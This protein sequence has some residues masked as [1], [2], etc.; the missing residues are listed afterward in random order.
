LL[1]ESH[2]PEGAP[3]RTWLE[4]SGAQLS[5]LEESGDEA[6]HAMALPPG[7]VSA[8]LGRYARPL[9][10]SLIDLPEAGGLSLPQG[11]RL[12]RLRFRPRYDVIAKD[13][14]VFVSEGH[15]P[16]AELATTL[17]A[18]LLHLARAAERGTSVG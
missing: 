15:E 8:V 6:V 17:S 1:H 12:L 18:A 5:L 13:Y 9:D 11:G 4:R 10:E 14:L 7:S 3:R 16:V 2:D